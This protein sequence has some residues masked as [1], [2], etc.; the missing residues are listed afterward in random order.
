MRTGLKAWIGASI[1]IMAMGGM[2][3]VTAT[4]LAAQGIPIC[5]NETSFHFGQDLF[6]VCT[7]EGFFKATPVGWQLLPRPT[8]WGQVQV[9][10]AGT[11]Y[12]YNNRTH[13]VYRST[14]EGAT[15]ELRG[16]TPLT[17]N[18][19]QTGSLLPAPVPDMVFLG[20]TD[21]PSPEP[22]GVY[23][24]TDGGSTWEWVLTGGNGR[25]VAFSPNFVTDGV[26]FVALD[27]Y[28][29]SIGVY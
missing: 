20:V 21:A 8:I 18:T 10:P 22:R 1:V 27:G 23:K 19:D 26:A 13:Q 3:L 16:H 14:D 15:W 12:L 24:S 9:A 2:L 28:R 25:W 17:P 4:P 7:R 6:L 5:S 29:T 11:L